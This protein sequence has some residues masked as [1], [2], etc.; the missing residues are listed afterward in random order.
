MKPIERREAL[1]SLLGATAATGL[2]SSTTASAEGA[3]VLTGGAVSEMMR[4]L[5]GL[6]PMPGEEER[7]R[8][9]LLSLR[10]ARRSDPRIEPSVHFDAETDVPA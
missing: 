2:L 1:R 7:V 4:S 5:L 3:Q 9:F 6:E 8:S 10:M